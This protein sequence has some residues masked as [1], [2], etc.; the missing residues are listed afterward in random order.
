MNKSQLN[1]SEIELFTSIHNTY[2]PNRKKNFDLK[3]V[4]FY[5]NFKSKV[6]I[7]SIIEKTEK[8][9]DSF[10]KTNYDS[11]TYHI[12][13]QQRNCGFQKKQKRTFDWHE[14]DYGAV[15]YKVHT[16]IYYIRKDN[17]IKGGSLEYRFNNQIYK[18]QINS[19][20]ILCF[21]GNIK[22]RPDICSGIGCRDII[23]VFLKR[24]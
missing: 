12:E 20:T 23:V 5:D 22:H 14:D 13:F 9:L 10:D 18:Q 16:V 17:T 1:D 24:I 7:E 11:S 3:S 8:I 15:D 2:L 19:G 4:S 21:E 6:M